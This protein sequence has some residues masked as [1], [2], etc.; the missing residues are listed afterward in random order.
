MINAATHYATL[1][2][3]D[4]AMHGKE[5]PVPS[6]D[7]IS[8]NDIPGPFLTQILRTL[9]TAGWVRAIRGSQGGYKLTVNPDRLTLLDLVDAMGGTE[10]PL[11]EISE[12]HA[13]N[14]CAVRRCW[15]D[16]SEAGR[17]ELGRVRLGDLVRQCQDTEAGMFY[18]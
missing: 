12:D 15:H 10:S 2:L 1:A 13:V 8:R 18:I 14:E 16:A 11:S 17:R 9:K 7:I 6:A 5:K 3:L 4:L